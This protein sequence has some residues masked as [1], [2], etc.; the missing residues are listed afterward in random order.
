MTTIGPE[1][2]YFEW[3]TQ[4]RYRRPHGHVAFFRLHARRDGT[5]VWMR[6]RL[7]HDFNNVHAENVRQLHR[8]AHMWDTARFIDGRPVAPHDL[9]ALRA[10]GLL[11]DQPPRV[12]NAIAARVMLEGT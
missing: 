6:T 9:D 12:L 3:T 2:A 7:V 5:L 8:V 4:A 10:R 11:R 1:V